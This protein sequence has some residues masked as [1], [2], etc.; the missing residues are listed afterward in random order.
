MKNSLEEFEARTA[1][2]RMLHNVYM[3]GI[4]CTLSYTEYM[5]EWNRLGWIKLEHVIG[6]KKLDGNI[7]SH[8]FAEIIITELGIDMLNF[9]LL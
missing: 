5:E 6:W 8:K 1:H 4:R 3:D 2:I 7:Y 9:R